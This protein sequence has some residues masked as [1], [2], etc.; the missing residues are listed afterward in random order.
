MAGGKK[1]YKLIGP[2]GEEYLSEEKGRPGGT[3][4]PQR[5]AFP[6]SP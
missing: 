3:I 4:I 1:L 5:Y 2:D 6:S